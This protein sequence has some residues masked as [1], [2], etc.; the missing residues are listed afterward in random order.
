MRGLGLISQD[1]T[2]EMAAGR[3]AVVGVDNVR[4]IEAADAVV[5]P[6][7]LRPYLM[8][9]HSLMVMG[10]LL[11]HKVDRSIPAMELAHQVAVKTR[12]AGQS[13]ALGM[14]THPKSTCNTWI[15]DGVGQVV[16]QLY[17]TLAQKLSPEG[18]DWPWRH[19]DKKLTCKIMKNANLSARNFMAVR[20]M[21]LAFLR[22]RADRIRPLGH[23][24]CVHC[25]ESNTDPAEHP[26]WCADSAAE[27]KGLVAEM[28]SIM[29]EEGYDKPVHFAEVPGLP[30]WLLTVQQTAMS[31]RRLVASRRVAMLL[32]L[33][34]SSERF[35]MMLVS[36]SLSRYVDWSGCRWS[37]NSAFT[38]KAK[39]LCL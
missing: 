39:N 29:R 2:L 19:A 35:A 25:D 31:E 12:K 30:R 3:T 6:L 27:R 38:G 20:G 14:P 22:T 23:T 7:W 36:M 21:Q 1:A 10:R 33:V 5:G 18:P 34:G 8:D 15:V 32:H 4:A 26:F 17:Q 13:A 9:L 24:D 28:R 37:A 11:L 16:N